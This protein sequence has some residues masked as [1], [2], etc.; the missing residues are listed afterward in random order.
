M[1]Q[2]D[3]HRGRF[4]DLP[5]ILLI[6][7]LYQNRS[8][9]VLDVEASDGTTR[10]WFKR[11]WLCHSA[12]DEA[13][14]LGHFLSM[15]DRRG[16]RSL[17]KALK[18]QAEDGK[19]LG[20]HLIALGALTPGGLEVALERQLS[21]R[22]RK[23]LTLSRGGFQ[24]VEGMGGFGPVP[25][26]A[27]L[28]NPLSLAAEAMDVV[29]EQ[30]LFWLEERLG[31]RWVRLAPGRRIPPALRA[32]DR[33][34]MLDRLPGWQEA[35]LFSRSARAARLG[36][37]LLGFG[38]L[39]TELRQSRAVPH[40]VAQRTHGRPV[41]LDKLS[42]LRS[43]GTWYELLGVS[44]LSSPRELKARYRSLALVCHPD[45]VEIGL[46]DQA[47]SLFAELAHAYHA[48]M[49]EQARAEYDRSLVVGGDWM[50]HGDPGQVESIFTR[51]S[52]E[53]MAAGRTNLA[54]E[55]QRLAAELGRLR[56]RLT[57]EGGGIRLPSAGSPAKMRTS[58][59]RKA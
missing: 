54:M 43:G 49:D 38:Y 1:I 44:P 16:Q 59:L 42:L 37:I 31:N 15:D 39:S 11:G 40:E 25:L 35:S 45:R 58:D 29:Q 21:A 33:D 9:G 23:V 50:R 32:R 7:R 28:S 14:H 46:Q 53:Q 5:A 3:E 22:L 24:F 12:G 36:A 48:L 4:S 20:Q 2:F 18:H 17:R 47:K 41:V 27:H 56:R 26:S 6:G 10:L 34:G 55:Y 57:M 19:L 30:D 13:T 51:R 8:T 52:D